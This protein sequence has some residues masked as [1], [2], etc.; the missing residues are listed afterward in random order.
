MYV[1]YPCRDI[2]NVTYILII[3]ILASMLNYRMY[4]HKQFFSKSMLLAIAVHKA[5][6]DQP[7]LL[8]LHSGHRFSLLCHHSEQ[9]ET[10]ARTAACHD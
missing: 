7:V 5:I 3:T 4:A 10:A 1:Y 2:K 8:H 9:Q 6:T